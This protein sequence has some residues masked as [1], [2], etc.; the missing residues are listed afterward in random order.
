M[1][2]VVG[3]LSGPWFLLCG[4]GEGVCGIQH[5]VLLSA[6]LQACHGPKELWQG[7]GEDEDNCPLEDEEPEVQ[8]LEPETQGDLAFIA[9]VPTPPCPIASNPP[10]PCSHPA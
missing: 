10:E 2:Q 8:R 4:A 6:P 5:R 9:G 7:W 3:P 1:R